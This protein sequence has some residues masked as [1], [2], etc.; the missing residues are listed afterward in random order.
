MPRNPILSIPIVSKLEIGPQIKAGNR[1]NQ[2]DSERSAQLSKNAALWADL[3]F[4]RQMD[5][6]CLN[7]RQIATATA[8]LAID[9]FFTQ[10]NCKPAI[11][12]YD[13]DSLHPRA[14]LEL[15]LIRDFWGGI[16]FFDRL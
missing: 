4:A 10:P 6:A 13:A 3:R 8:L 16:D 15:L 11:M 9:R 1:E 12:R 5:A 14:A 2:V 7:L